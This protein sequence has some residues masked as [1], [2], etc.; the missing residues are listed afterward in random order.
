[1]D[2]FI[3]TGEMVFRA[4]SV[5]QM[6]MKHSEEQPRVPSATLPNNGITPEL[7]ALVLSKAL[8]YGQTVH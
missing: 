6:A 4:G 8:E 7:D 1:M 3:L 5:L 2:D